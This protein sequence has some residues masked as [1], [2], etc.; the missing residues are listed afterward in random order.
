MS[1]ESSA[2][3]DIK[4]FYVERIICKRDLIRGVHAQNMTNFRENQKN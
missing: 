3:S 4:N 1:R 2:K